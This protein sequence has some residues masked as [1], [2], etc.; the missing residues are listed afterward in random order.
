[1]A[2]SLRLCGIEDMKITMQYNTFPLYIEDFAK[3]KVYRDIK[4]YISVFI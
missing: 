2:A 3:Y 4:F 1:M